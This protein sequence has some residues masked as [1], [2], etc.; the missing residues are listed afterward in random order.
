MQTPPNGQAGKHNDWRAIS[1]GPTC[2]ILN[3]NLNRVSN[4]VYPCLETSSVS[5]SSFWQNSLWRVSIV[6]TSRL[7]FLMEGAVNSAELHEFKAFNAV[8]VQEIGAQRSLLPSRPVG[9]GFVKG[10]TRCSF[11]L[12]QLVAMQGFWKSRSLSWKIS[13]SECYLT[14]Y[15]LGRTAKNSK[16]QARATNSRSQ[17]LPYN[18]LTEHGRIHSAVGWRS[19]SALR[20]SGSSLDE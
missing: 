5:R 6:P 14:S 4:M 18:H 2:N 7:R 19:Q 17:T 15:V 1:M 10:V 13:H 16:Q 11:K 8:L 3:V 20:G 9:H 12:T